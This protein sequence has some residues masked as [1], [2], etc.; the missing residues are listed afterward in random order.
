[1]HNLTVCLD[2]LLKYLFLHL[3]RA[4]VSLKVRRAAAVFFLDYVDAAKLFHLLNLFHLIDLRLQEMLLGC[5][6]LVD[7]SILHLHGRIFVFLIE[8][9]LVQLDPFLLKCFTQLFQAEVRPILR[10]LLQLF[11][12]LNFQYEPLRLQAAE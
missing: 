12:L 8:P 1:M 4:G 11:K 6:K 5:R 9:C 10:L 3:I 2:H 7:E